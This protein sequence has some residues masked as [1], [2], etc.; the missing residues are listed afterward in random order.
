MQIPQWIPWMDMR[1]GQGRV[2]LNPLNG[3]FHVRYQQCPARYSRHYH[4]PASPLL[5]LSPP[6]VVWTRSCSQVPRPLSILRQ[7]FSC[8]QFFGE[9]PFPRIFLFSYVSR[10]PRDLPSQ[11]SSC[12]SYP[13]FSQNS[14]LWIFYFSSLN[15]PTQHLVI[16]HLINYSQN[17]STQYTQYIL[18]F[19]NGNESRSKERGDSVCIHIW[20]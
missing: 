3:Q 17:K 13:Q 16:N 18:V 6:E 4:P 2:D 15:C 7:S 8:Q 9:F 12:S 14:F 11:C 20:L 19:V 10:W 1:C 5:L